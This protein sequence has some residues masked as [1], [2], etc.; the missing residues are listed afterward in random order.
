[1][2]YRDLH[3]WIVDTLSGDSYFTNGTKPVVIL[4]Q[5]HP[6]TPELSQAALNDSGIVIVV[7]PPALRRTGGIQDKEFLA[8]CYIVIFESPNR[9][10]GT[11]GT[12]KNA[13]NLAVVAASI[14]EEQRPADFWAPLQFTELSQAETSDEI[15]VWV[16]ELQT[17][18]MIDLLALVLGDQD[19]N[20]LTDEDGNLISVSPSEP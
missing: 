3:Q 20:A 6:T 11:K 4:P 12:G 7:S 8:T 10:R 5:D 17:R 13:W 18:L 2:I 1:M 14:L 15:V 19:G 9:N 16:V